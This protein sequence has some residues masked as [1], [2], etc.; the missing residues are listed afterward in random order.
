MVKG[1]VSITL[2]VYHT[3]LD[4][5]IL[6]KETQDKFKI[7]SKELQVFLSFLASRGD[8]EKYVDEFNKQSKTSRIVFEGTSAKIEIKDDQS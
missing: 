1:T 5:A 2:E 4:S 7:A 8:I 6:S 3:F